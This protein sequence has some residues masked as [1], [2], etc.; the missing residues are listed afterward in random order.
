MKTKK[1]IPAKTSTKPSSFALSFFSFLFPFSFFL[2]FL[3][4]FSL[5][6]SFLQFGL[7]T[8]VGVFIFYFIFCTD[9]GLENIFSKKPALFFILSTG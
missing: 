6:V 5:V 1:D 7:L 9:D 4:C 3:A 2:S 8:K